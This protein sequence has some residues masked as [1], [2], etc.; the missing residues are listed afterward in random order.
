MNQADALQPKP[1]A[2][3]TGR[4]QS[5][6]APGTG[7]A[8]GRGAG[9]TGIGVD[10]AAAPADS[11]SVFKSVTG[12]WWWRRYFGDN[13]SLEHELD[14]KID[15]LRI[16]LL[17]M[18]SDVVP[19]L[20]TGLRQGLVEQLDQ[21]GRLLA[22]CEPF[23][24]VMQRINFVEAE[25]MMRLADDRLDL[26]IEALRAEA[27]ISLPEVPARRCSTRSRSSPARSTRRRSARSR[28]SGSRHD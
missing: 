20:D 6:G 3:P 7:G 2:G 23:E 11:R 26:A 1:E 27:S 9:A 8:G 21:A 16:I 4:P 24:R 13:F 28:S 12:N 18:S 5:D 14:A 19:A 10:R 17:T 15:R 22:D 25:I